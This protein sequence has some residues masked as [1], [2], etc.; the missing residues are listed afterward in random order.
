MDRSR[1]DLE[2]VLAQIGQAYA[3]ALLEGDEIAAELAGRWSA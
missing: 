1:Q 3:R 2:Q